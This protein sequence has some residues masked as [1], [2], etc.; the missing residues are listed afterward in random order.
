MDGH[1]I[2]SPREVLVALTAVNTDQNNFYICTVH[3]LAG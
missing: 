2:S 3:L 1:V